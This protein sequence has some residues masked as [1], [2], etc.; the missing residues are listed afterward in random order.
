MHLLSVF[1][2]R[3]RALIALVT[4]VVAVFGTISLTSLKQELIPSVSF[5]QL[6]VVTPYPGAAPEVVNEDVS[7]PI[8]TAIQ[9]VA[10]LE[11]TT[12]TSRTNISTVSASF[13]YGTDLATAEQKVTQAINRI[14][15]TLPEDV[16]P[17]VITG[18]VD[19]LPVI[20]I[21]VTSDLEIRELSASLEASTLSDIQ[22]LEGVREASLLGTIGERVT[23][24]PDR[25]AL[26]AVGASNADITDALDANGVLLPAGDLTEGDQT[27][28]VQAGS[29]LSSVEEIAAL[30]LSGVLTD[31]GEA[32]TIADV[33]DVAI[34][35]NPVEGISRVN[36][37]PSLTIAVTKT[38]AGNTVAVSNAV[39][40]AI[41]ELEAA[42]GEGTEFTV[43]FDQAPFIEQ[44][45]ESLATEGV[46][47]LVFA[48]IVILVFLLSIRSTLV[49]A[50]SIPASVL[51][52]FIGMQAS[53]YTLNIITLGALTISVGR[54]VDDSIVVI[55][56]IKRHIGLGENKLEAIQSAV[57]EVAVAVTSA[58]VTTVAVFLPLALVGDITGELFRPFALTVTIALA[59]SLLVSLTIV[60]VLAYWFLGNESEASRRERKARKKGEQADAAPPVEY[61]DT[62]TAALQALTPGVPVPSRRARREAA[63]AAAAQA[64]ELEKPSR[65]Q[66]GYLPVIR[67]TLKRPALTIGAAVLV[68]LLTVAMLPF[69][70]T[71]F[72]GDSGQ[73][74]LTV[75]QELELGSSLE[76]QD[77][78]AM[79]VEEALFGVEGVETVQLSLGSSGSSLQAAFGGGGGATFSITTDPDADQEQVQADVRAAIT[80]LDDVGELSISTSGSGFASN[81]IDVD[82]Q[83]P[84]QE[85]LREATEAVLEEVRGLD[86]TAEA[87]SNLS[88]S[89]PYIA[90]IVDRE[91]AAERGLS[92]IAVGGIVSQAMLPRAVGTVVIDDTSLSI[93][94]ENP[95]APETIEELRDFRV[96]TAAG[97][98]PL[99]A[100]ASVEEVD[101]PASITTIRGVR[102]A[103]VSVTPN[104]DDVGTAS[105]TI[106]AAI[107]ELDLPAGTEAELGGVTAQ[108]GDAFEQLGIALLVAILIVYVVMVAT[109]KSLRQPLLLL[110]SV[111]FAAT[112]AI[113]LQVATGIPLGVPSLI[114]VLM[115][116][117]IVVT[118]AIVLVDLVNQYRVKGMSA[119][120]AVVH[121]S[122]RRLRPI[123]MT[124]LATIFALLPLGIGLTGHGGFISQPLAIVVI[125]GLVSSTLLTLVVLPSLYYLVEGAK[126]RREAKRAAAAS[127]SHGA[128]AA[129]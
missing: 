53:G 74:T 55:E 18:S 98:V 9:G 36:G 35:D 23:I 106:Q 24:T 97:L 76:A 47:G 109:F 62:S 101:G 84:G 117:G 6:V 5:P 71:N 19:D 44:S 83:A 10:G 58:T 48:V 17:Q 77:E 75:T 96:P 81:D 61:V 90:V 28:S 114:G 87:S 54:V 41:P 108:Q 15:S 80:E 121:G 30:P 63:A 46:L 60:P 50:I 2:L 104:G 102:S 69:M 52:T 42:I 40:D 99:T 26:A 91:E 120:D 21:A 93:Y 39:Q 31:A 118:N 115:L 124:A 7:T 86:V 13:E 94:I 65:L 57:K 33:A 82:I 37:E 92:E 3:N 64:D 4:I 66:R 126:E 20:Q 12:A 95:T 67:F 32:V 45:I 49:T 112:G 79:Q 68:L 113:A 8:E 116:I 100:I 127:E 110:V 128:H 1:S 129:E 51:I 123:L 56:N 105:A 78:A 73:N 111:P 125:G 89:Q 11:G 14:S 72:I 119:Y 122:S 38:P 103:T 34:T 43:V 70:K 107:D 85:A 59:A 22:S 27:L 88:V 29:R 16:D 25:A